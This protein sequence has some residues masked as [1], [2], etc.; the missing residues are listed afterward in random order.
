MWQY[1]FLVLDSS[2]YA[3]VPDLQGTDSGPLA[4]LGSG[5]KTIGRA[6]IYFPRLAFLRFY[7]DNYLSSSLAAQGPKKKSVEKHTAHSGPLGVIAR[8]LGMT[9][10]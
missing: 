10:A 9:T 1:V 2:L 5:N 6:N 3:G 4:H 8:S 7:F